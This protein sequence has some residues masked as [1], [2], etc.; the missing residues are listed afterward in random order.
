MIYLWLLAKLV[1]RWSR[2]EWTTL[3]VVLAAGFATLVSPFLITL[4]NH[5]LGTFAVL[6]AVYAAVRIHE[7]RQAGMRPGPGL[8][9]VAG[10]SAGFATCMELPALAFLAAL[11]GLFFLW[12]PVRTVAFYL[13]GAALP[14]AAFFVANWLAVGQ[15]RPAYS[16]FGGPWY[17]YEGS[18]WRPPAAGETKRGIDWARYHETRAEYALHVL[19]GHHG[20][21][22]LTP[23]WLLALAGMIVGLWP[24]PPPEHGQAPAAPPL[25]WFLPALT[26]LVSAVVIGFYLVKSD[27]YGGFTL[28]LRWLMWLTPLWLLCVVPVADGLSRW[29]A[30][31]L[32][33]YL[34]LF[35]SALSANYNPWNPWRHPWLYDLMIALGWPGY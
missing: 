27:N 22:S 16:E 12:S 13:L 21:F 1:L 4:N 17:E 30:G 34:C 24:K 26:L 8:L 28:G 29:P 2:S 31:R 9:F 35:I 18:H 25:P 19:V 5:T 20:W 6:G 10:L 23:L 11:G 32:V 3:L 33:V 14:I 15:L 7:G